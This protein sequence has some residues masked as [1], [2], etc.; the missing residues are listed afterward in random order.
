MALIIAFGVGV[1][2]CLLI[3]VMAA[4]HLDPAARRRALRHPI[5]EARARLAGDADDDDG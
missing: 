4:A 1:I 3:F 2:P 5:A